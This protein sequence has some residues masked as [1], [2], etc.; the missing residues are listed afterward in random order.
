M[1]K[2]QHNKIIAKRKILQNQPNLK[3]STLNPNV[4][5]PTEF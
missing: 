1:D 4:F 2:Q 3:G 5:D